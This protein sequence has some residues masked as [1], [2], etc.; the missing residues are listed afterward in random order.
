[1]LA[2]G[3][4]S[5]ACEVLT[6][7]KFNPKLHLWTPKEDALVGTV[8]DPALAKQLG[9][10]ISAVAHRR[11]RLGLG[12]RYAHRR[13]WTP[14]EDALLGTASDTEIAA[15]LDR[16]IA[17]VCIRRQKLGIPNLY[18]QRRCGRQRSLGKK[19]ADQYTVGRRFLGGDSLWKEWR[20]AHQSSNSLCGYSGWRT[21]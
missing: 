4:L 2:T 20:L 5:L 3:V 16:H 10:T 8:T 17:T 9:I 12:V 7:P 11:R 1:M 19:T 18:W 14:E 15:R 13:P 21:L 6:I